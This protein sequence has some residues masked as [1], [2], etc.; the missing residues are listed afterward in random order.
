MA[1]QL[2]GKGLNAQ[3]NVT[4]LVDV[5]LVLLII[6]MVIT[7]ML[8]RGKAVMLPATKQPEKQADDGKDLVV[9]VEYIRRGAGFMINLYLGRNL[10]DETALR[11]RLQDELRKDPSREIYLKGD[12]RLNYGAM[13]KVMELCHQSG[14]QQVKL[15][16]DEDKSGGKGS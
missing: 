13:R 2:G 12:Q 7:P 15:A 6:F 16:T 3:I 1:M 5:M 8:Q 11:N 14:F 9:S 4:P 10:V